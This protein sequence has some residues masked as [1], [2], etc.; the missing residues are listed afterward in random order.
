MGEVLLDLFMK[1]LIHYDSLIGV[2][3]YDEEAEARMANEIWKQLP[4]CI[5]WSVAYKI[6]PLCFP[7]ATSIITNKGE[8]A[9]GSFTWLQP[10]TN[11]KAGGCVVCFSAISLSISE[12]SIPLF[13][14]VIPSCLSPLIL[15]YCLYFHA[16]PGPQRTEPI[17]SLPLEGHCAVVFPNHA[18]L[19]KT[20]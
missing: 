10:P 13:L 1:N 4:T 11:T 12:N 19:A 20:I 18:P 5:L 16:A 9:P 15:E 14:Q 3:C 7:I 6:C 17:S 8:A 2:A